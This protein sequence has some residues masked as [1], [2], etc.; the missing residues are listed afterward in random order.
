VEQR[1]RFLE[2]IM[3]PFSHFREYSFSDAFFHLHTICTKI[4]PPVPRGGLCVKKKE[5]ARKAAKPQRPPEVIPSASQ[6]LCA[7]PP[8]RTGLC[9]KKKNVP[10]VGFIQSGLNFLK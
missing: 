1:K 3:R 8:R 7:C 6:F 4:P 5:I 2:A 9:A 10:R